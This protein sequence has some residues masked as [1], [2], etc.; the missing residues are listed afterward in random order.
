MPDPETTSG[1]WADHLVFD[2]EV[3]EDSPVVKGTWITVGHVV[4]MIIDGWTW[5]DI[6]RT[7]PE[8]TEEDI[9]ACLAYTIDQ[10]DHF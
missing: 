5:T 7:H 8:L 1:R 6:L 4:S 10:D 9:Q 2:P 3:S